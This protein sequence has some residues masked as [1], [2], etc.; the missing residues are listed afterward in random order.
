MY[1]EVVRPERIVNTE[2]FEPAWYTGFQALSTLVLTTEG[3]GTLMTIT[4][5]Y[6]SKKTRDEILAS[7]M[8][9]GLEFS[10]Q[11]LDSLLAAKP[12]KIAFI[13]PQR[14]GQGRGN[15]L[16]A[17]ISEPETVDV[18]MKKL[19]HPLKPVAEQLRKGDPERGQVDRRRHPLECAVFLL[20][21]EDEALRPEDLQALR[22]GLQLL[23]AGHAPPHLP[24]AAPM[25]RTRRGCSRATTRTAAGSRSTPASP[26]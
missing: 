16:F 21:R 6:G 9:G 3:K 18:Y 7:P 13:P 17:G 14:E 2:Q 10:Y 4:A 15:A 12:K 1:K 23:Q 24:C 19:K 11:A 22:R 5:R 26:K 25:W 8:E 20:H